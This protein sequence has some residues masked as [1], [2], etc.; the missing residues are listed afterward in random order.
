MTEASS[1]AK[2]N[3]ASIVGDVYAAIATAETNSAGI[4]WRLTD[5]GRQLDANLLQL[6]PQQRIDVHTEP[7]LDVLVF[8]VTGTGTLTTDG[9]PLTLTAGSLVWLP[10]GTTRGL[11]AGGRGLAYLTV[12]PRRPGMQIGRLGGSGR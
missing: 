8:V 7:D 2:P 9:R 4:Q 3:Q 5:S 1:T 6:A 10:R 11:A 12:H